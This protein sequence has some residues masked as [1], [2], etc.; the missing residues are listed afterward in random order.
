M[1]T[2][3]KVTYNVLGQTVEF[4]DIARKYFHVRKVFVE[5]ADSQRERFVKHF[6]QN[7]SSLEDIVAKGFKDGLA[8]IAPAVEQCLRFLAEYEIYEYDENVLAQNIVTKIPI[9]EKAVEKIFDSYQEIVLSEAELDAARIAR[10]EGRGR[11]IGGG[12][13]VGGAIKGMAMAGAANMAIGAMHA[14][15]N[16]IGKIFSTIGC[17][18]KMSEVF[19]KEAEEQTL[20]DA[21]RRTIYNSH[22]YVIE[23]INLSKGEVVIE[24]LYTDERAQKAQATLRNLEK[25][26]P[27]DMEALKKKYIELI[28]LCPYSK[29]LFPAIL[30]DFGDANGELEMLGKDLDIKVR[31]QKESI[32]KDILTGEL[33]RKEIL[34]SKI[35][36][37]MTQSRFLGLSDQDILQKII[38]DLSYD[39]LVSLLP[40]ICESKYSSPL[41]NSIAV[42]FSNDSAVKS[43]DIDLLRKLLEIFEQ[44]CHKQTNA[45]N[46]AK[47]IIKK[48]FKDIKAVERDKL[49]RQKQALRFASDVG[50]RTVY[51]IM[52]ML[53]FAIPILFG[54]YFVVKGTKRERALTLNWM[55][56]L[57]VSYFIHLAGAETLA[58]MV[59]VLAFFALPVVWYISRPSPLST[60]EVE[61]EV[62][63]SDK[64]KRKQARKEI[65]K[66][67]ENI[68]KS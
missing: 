39:K 1:H 67:A 66:A 16:G 22:L 63:S 32:L 41:I 19:S 23:L 29:D 65:L 31:L 10:R 52:L 53:T 47:Q 60:S 17:S 12:F 57:N 8:F 3:D 51:F 44:D 55:L 4:C 68:P 28:F 14:T 43:L 37:A 54:W 25:F 36:E 49:K 27:K 56:L 2:L 48:V 7:Y 58:S 30:R 45:I 62:D 15:F 24:A 42:K 13:G 40:V 38:Q 35:E 34:D 26:P 11:I 64:Q 5:L 61:A 33:E 9:Y 6:I 18:M 59:F 46:N 20:A 21:I 50:Y